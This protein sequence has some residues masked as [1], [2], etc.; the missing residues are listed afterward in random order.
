MNQTATLT[1]PATPARPLRPI[2]QAAAMGLSEGEWLT[3]HAA[4]DQ[5]A[6]IT[7][8]AAPAK[9]ILKALTPLGTVMALTRN[10]ACVH[11]KDGIYDKIDIG[12]GMGLVVNYDID[13]RLFMRQWASAYAVET[14]QKDGSLRHSLQ[15]FDRHGTA[16]HKIFARPV[17]DMTAWAALVERFAGDFEPITATPR[18]APAEERPDGEIDVAALRDGWTELKDVHDF[19]G[20][21]RKLG[22]GRQQALRL[23][24]APYA[25]PIAT[26]AIRQLLMDCA[27]KQ[28][29]IMCFVGNE[30]CIQ[31]HS[32]PVH[33]IKVMGPWLNVLDKGFNLHLREDMIAAAYA[34]WKPQSDAAVHSIELFAEDGSMIA[35][36]FGERKPGIP[37]I[38]AW[39]EHVQ[40]IPTL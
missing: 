20:M 13:L 26:D 7:R 36:F 6:R 14:P 32:G 24:G 4:D 27:E 9:D 19:F 16:I 31:I 22:A 29:P 33:N 10:P 40:A 8:L 39:A 38:P 5:G 37:E 2:E 21:L 28:V 25:R 1:Q 23:A 12:P 30:G 11:E 17:T 34:V 15:F 3:R 35:Q 18:A